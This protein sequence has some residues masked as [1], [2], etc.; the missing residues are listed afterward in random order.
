M[1]TLIPP[2]KCQ[3]IKTKLAS[4]IKRLAPQFVSGRW[5]EPF[6]GSCVVALNIL[7][8]R[9][10][11]TDVNKHII[12]FYQALQAGTMTPLA[13]RAFLT[14][15]GAT[16]AREG[17]AYYYTVRERF[18]TTEQPLDFLFLSR[19]CFNGVMRFN[20]AGKFN[21]PFCRKP[22][23][24]SQAYIT[25]IVNQAQTMVD[26]MR[27]KDW[28]FA[29]A[30]FRQTLRRAKEDDFVYADPPYIGRHVD[31]YNSWTA[32]DEQDL[33]Q[34]LKKIPCDFL[35]STWYG[36][37]HRTNSGVQEHWDDAAFTINTV[38]HFYHVGAMESLRNAMT[39]ALIMNHP[40]QKMEP[41]LTDRTTSSIQQHTFA[42]E[43][44]G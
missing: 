15:E 12:G 23:R 14:E 35:L 42:W 25:K 16:L 7:P 38:E 37:R 1:K 9:A 19:A 36:N 29:V 24:F 28:Q 30:D 22:Q 3:G 20:R 18:N 11:L 21:V 6:C 17:E 27:A 8:E 2:I 31:Y 13:I 33:I 39:E 32:A 40:P 26:A 5:I 44:A 34:S 4:H 43:A 41:R 10:L